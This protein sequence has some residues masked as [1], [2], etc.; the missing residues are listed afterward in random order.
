[1]QSHGEPLAGLNPRTQRL[2]N[3]NVETLLGLIQQIVAQRKSMEK[4]K[5][6]SRR[7]IRQHSSNERVV[8]SKTTPLEEVKEIIHLPEF[9]SSQN[10][11]DQVKPEEVIVPDQVIQQL[12]VLVSEIARRYNDNPFHNFDHASHVVISGE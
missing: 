4:T 11:Q 3:W 10:G 7:G 2:V 9:N 8:D 6:A 1:M 5:N 12:H